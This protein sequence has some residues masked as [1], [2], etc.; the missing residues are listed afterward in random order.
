MKQI[1]IL[2]ILLLA[3]VVL[4]QAQDENPYTQF[5]YEGKVLKTPQGNYGTLRTTELKNDSD[6]QA[7][8]Q[9]IIVGEGYRYGF[10]GM[11]KDDEIKGSGNSYDFGERMYDAR[12]GRWW[13]LDPLSFN[14]PDKSDY[15]YAANNPVNNVDV[16]GEFVRDKDGNLVVTV[17]STGIQEYTIISP[18]DKTDA[19]GNVINDYHT[20][21]GYWGYILTDKGNRVQVFV[22]SSNDVIISSATGTYPDLNIISQQQVSDRDG[23]YN[24]ATNSLVAGKA[25]KNT[26]ISSDQ[27][28]Q[29]VLD[30]EGYVSA[31]GEPIKGDVGRYYSDTKKYIE[32]FE[33]YLSPEKVDSKGG[34]QKGPIEMAPG[35]NE[36]F[37]GTTYS[38]IRRNTKLETS[39]YPSDFA[40]TLE[41]NGL[42]SSGVDNGK[43]YESAGINV[44]DMED[45]SKIEKD[46]KQKGQ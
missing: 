37:E 21:A 12:L 36:G 11:E 13:G 22:P 46:V 17:T 25:G 9:V 7:K 3:V 28:T 23:K 8:G 27:I 26:I 14:Y 1:L 4:A 5:G 31:E 6:Y 29:D 20:V 30:D 10:N 16:N 15:S 35:T 45:F 44:V 38:V 40:G 18:T 43:V 34:T 19:K 2:L 42:R 32:H 41:S 39:I 24:C 33:I